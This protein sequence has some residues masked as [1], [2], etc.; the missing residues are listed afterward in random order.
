MSV[1][2][3]AEPILYNYYVTEGISEIHLHRC[4]K[5]KDLGVLID[6]KSSFEYSILGIIKR[7]FAHVGKES[8]VLYKSMVR[9]RLEFSNSV[10]SPYKVGLI[11]MLEKVQKRATKM[12]SNC[13]K[14]SYFDR[15]KY[16]GIPTLK[17]RRYRGDMIETYKILHG[18][19]DCT[20]SPTLPRYDFTATRG[21][22]F[23]LVKHYCK[24]DMRKFFY[25]ENY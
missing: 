12:V 16:L 1:K 13:S 6:S 3:H 25:S 4:E 22:N 24:Y 18:F 9:S 8:F 17:Y 15:L 5:V 14:L 19:Y 23:K 10:W 11:D 20:V 2:P 21:N 7:N